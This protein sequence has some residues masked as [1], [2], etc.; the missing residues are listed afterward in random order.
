MKMD[1]WS[2]K[3]SPSAQTWGVKGKQKEKKHKGKPV[4]LKK[5]KAK[6]EGDLM[7]VVGDK[8]RKKK[9]KNHEW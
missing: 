2:Q 8:Q 9:D 6:I 7:N 5:T 1:H 3:G 4:T